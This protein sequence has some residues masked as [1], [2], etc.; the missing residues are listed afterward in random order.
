[1]EKI[2]VRNICMC[3]VNVTVNKMDVQDLTFAV[4][5]NFLFIYRKVG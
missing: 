2:V 1:M 3:N 4:H 5:L